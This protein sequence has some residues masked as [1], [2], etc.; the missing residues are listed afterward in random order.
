MLISSADLLGT[1]RVAARLAASQ[2]EQARDESPHPLTHL[3]VAE[4][5]LVQ[6]LA[7]VRAASWG[8]RRRSPS[9]DDGDLSLIL[10]AEEAAL[11]A[12]AGVIPSSPKG[13]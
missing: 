4:S 2:I 5:R 7:E 12:A 1:A 9:F 3:A 10:D 11:V 8:I 6:A 13:R